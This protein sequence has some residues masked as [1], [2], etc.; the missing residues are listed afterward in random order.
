MR[1]PIGPALGIGLIAAIIAATVFDLALIAA[2]GLKPW[3][4]WMLP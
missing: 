1:I 2:H 3:L 4:G